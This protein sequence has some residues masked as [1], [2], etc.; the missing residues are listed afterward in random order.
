MNNLTL[1]NLS[2]P[3]EDYFK[4]NFQVTDEMCLGHFDP[5]R[6]YG[7]LPGAC[8]FG[9]VCDYFTQNNNRSI[10]A[11]TKAQFTRL[12]LPSMEVL[13]EV[14]IK[15]N[16]VRVVCF[17]EGRSAATMDLLLTELS[18]S[19]DDCPGAVSL[20]GTYLPSD[21]LN[22]L[23]PF[24]SDFILIRDVVIGEDCSFCLV[25][26]KQDP[27][28]FDDQ[29]LKL[30]GLI[31][32]GNHLLITHVLSLHQELVGQVPFLVRLT[33][34][35][36][37]GPRLVNPNCVLLMVDNLNMRGNHGRARVI[38]CQ[39]DV[40]EIYRAQVSFR[41]DSSGVEHKYQPGTPVPSN[42]SPALP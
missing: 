9:L 6:H 26:S 35:S 40:T 37:S 28:F 8:L 41:S 17:A 34:V 15:G 27:R 24:S 2:L 39:T 32:A 1:E 38:G 5:K 33:D 22:D 42:P 3:K 23:L 29:R 11:I 31:E 18:G 16:Q 4:I 7:V 25:R 12:I 21:Q 20:A 14:W 10:T 19:Q 36:F 13:I 30:S